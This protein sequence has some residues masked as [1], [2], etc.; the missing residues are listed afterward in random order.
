MSVDERVES[1]KSD[2]GTSRAEFSELQRFLIDTAAIRMHRNLLKI[3]DRA[4]V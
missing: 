1:R 3:K 4:H 2:A